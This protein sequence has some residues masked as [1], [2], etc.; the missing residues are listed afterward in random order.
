MVRGPGMGS[1]LPDYATAMSDPRFAKKPI[2]PVPPPPYAAVVALPPENP[3]TETTSSEG[4]ASA[5]ANSNSNPT[6][7]PTEDPKP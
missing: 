2:Y 4:V 7:A 5:N 1:D 6:D 3:P